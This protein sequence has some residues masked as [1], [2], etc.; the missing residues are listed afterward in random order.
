LYAQ[1]EATPGLARNTLRAQDLWMAI[2]RTKRETGIPYIMF[3]DTCNRCSNQQNLG[4]IRSS[5]LC[6]EIVEYTAPDEIAVCN[7]A[8]LNLSKYPY[9]TETGAWE[10]DYDLLLETTRQVTIN[11]N[12]VIDRNYYPLPEAETSNLKH[13]PIGIGVQA[14]ADAFAIMGMPFDS[15]QARTLNEQIFATIYYGAVCQ[16]VEE[17]KKYGHYTTFPGSPASKGQ[18]HFDLMRQ[19]VTPLAGQF[20]P[21]CA[22]FDWETLRADMMQ[23]GLRNS[24][25]IAPMPTASTSQILG[26]NECFEPFTSNAYSRRVLA[27]T[28]T[29]VN[30]HMVRDFMAHGLW[31]K[32]MRTLIVAANG[33]IQ[34]IDGIPAALKARYKTTWEISQRA[35]LQMASDR[36][37]YIDQSQSLNVHM[38]SPTLAQLDALHF[39]AWEQELKTGSYY[40][41]SRPRVD[42]IKITV[43]HR[44]IVDA[45]TRRL[46]GEGGGGGGGGGSKPTSA[47]ASFAEECDMCGS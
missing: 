9:Q 7:L 41:R 46:R 29:V 14:L 1:Y 27:G 4:T 21:R 8:S 6:T 44:T 17:A 35:V 19:A 13:R 26:N 34:D 10:F 47:N 3:K 12:Q 2:K 38:A 24:L 36:Q 20:G 43:D 16:S 15:P 18:F 39:F 30:E 33:S 28:F 31:T 45:E 32:R 40:L 37:R 23:Y 5:N 42:P 22:A 11:L 25:L